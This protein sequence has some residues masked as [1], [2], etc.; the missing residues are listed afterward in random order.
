MENGP[1]CSGERGR[2]RLW[3]GGSS[4]HNEGAC[5]IRAV[6]AQESGFLS[7]FG[8]GPSSSCAT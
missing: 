4:R 7:Q 8:A 2:L 6:I 5:A 3:W 1:A